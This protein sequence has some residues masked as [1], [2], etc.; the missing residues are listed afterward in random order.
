MAMNAQV[1]LARRP[2]GWVE[3]SHFTIVETQMPTPAPGEIL[4]R[5]H[6]LSLDPYMRGRMSDAK[7]YAAPVEIGQ[8]MGGGTISEVI[9]SHHP[10]FTSGDFVLGQLGW[11]EYAR[12]SGEAL[13]KVSPTPIPLTCYLGVAGMPGATA[14]IGLYEHCQPKAGETVVVSAAAGAVG[15]VAGQLA[16]LQGCRAVGIAGGT[17]KCDHVVQ[18]LGFDACVDYKKGNL[19]ESLAAAVPD[20]IDCYFENV[21]GQVLDA[22]LRRLNPFSRMALCGL[23]A[24]YNVPEPIG[25]RMIR[26]L[27]VNRVKVQ[28]FIVLDRQ[29]L[30]TKAVK[31]LTKWVAQRKIR[32]HETIAEG[33]RNAPRAFIGMMRGENLGKQLVRLV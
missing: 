3:E 28:G 1:L 24:E 11:Q 6:W 20:G 25:M 27:L 7:S 32:Y 33:L 12:S 21:G 4:L 9:E 10:K 16:R 29:D 18:E 31:Q 2:D 13:L 15:S 22:V 8:V 30:Y 19:E 17:M 14:W 23:I 26:S 5:N